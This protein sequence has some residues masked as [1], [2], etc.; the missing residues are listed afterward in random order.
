MM[1]MEEEVSNI[2]NGGRDE[3]KE[4]NI[5]LPVTEALLEKELKVIMATPHSTSK[6]PAVIMWRVHDLNDLN[7]VNDVMW[8]IMSMVVIESAKNIDRA[9]THL[10]K[11]FVS[12]LRTQ[13]FLDFWD[14][15]GQFFIYLTHHHLLVL[16]NVQRGIKLKVFSSTWL[17]LVIEM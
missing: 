8:C 16:S 6:A 2:W 14:H 11:L 3:R 12:N 13:L 5:D 9:R 10:P 17:Q 4:R 7:D 1:M 15:G